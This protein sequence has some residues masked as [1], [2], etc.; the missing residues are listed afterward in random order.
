M[1]IHLV[2]I[3]WH[4]FIEH[5]AYVYYRIWDGMKR[6]RRNGLGVA[7]CSR[8][9]SSVY[10]GFDSASFRLSTQRNAKGNWSVFALVLRQNS[11]GSN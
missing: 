11:R 10:V 7:L 6:M 3:P 2:R 4:F 8:N 1:L 9:T 5:Q